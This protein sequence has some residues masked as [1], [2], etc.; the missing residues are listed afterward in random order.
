MMEMSNKRCH[1]CGNAEAN[2]RFRV[3]EMML[4]YRDEFTYF[5]CSQCGCLQ[6]DNIPLDISKYYPADYYSYSIDVS[7]MS[8]AAIK[9]QAQFVCDF[10]FNG[11]NITADSRILDVGSGGGGHLYLLRE[12]GFKHLLGVDPYLPKTIE[13][14]NRVRV[15]RAE[16]ADLDG[17]WDLIMFNHSFEHLNNPLEVLR[18][19]AEK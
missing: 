6:I 18:E 17:K 7:K 3:L 4:G 15:I 9:K 16:L 8:A 12:I 14:D 19:V 5:Q 2:R 1:I 11:T 10:Y 13:H